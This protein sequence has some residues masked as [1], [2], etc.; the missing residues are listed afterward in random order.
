MQRINKDR[1]HESEFIRTNQADTARVTLDEVLFDS[2]SELTDSQLTSAGIAY[3]EGSGKWLKAN[4]QFISLTSI[5]ISIP[6]Y[7]AFPALSS[8]D[9]KEMPECFIEAGRNLRTEEFSGT[10]TGSDGISRVLV[11]RVKLLYD[12][13]ALLKYAVFTLSNCSEN[14]NENELLES[15]E[16]LYK[17]FEQTAVGIFSSDL[18]GRILRVN[19]KI[20]LMLQYTQEELLRMNIAEFI[21]NDELLINPIGFD[22]LAKGK[23]TIKERRIK[24]KDGSIIFAEV[25]SKMFVP[26]SFTGVVRD[27]T[28]R[29]LVEQELKESEEQ[30]RRLVELSPN[31]LLIQSGGEIVYV[32]NAGVRLFRAE[33]KMQ[34]IG[35]K[36]PALIHPDYIQLVRER[37]KV[38]SEG[39]SVPMAEEKYICMDGSIL[40]V[41]VTAA[42]FMFKGNQAVQVIMVD[43]S[44]RKAAEEEVNNYKNHLEH[45][46]LSRTA[47]LEE[48]NSKLLEEI[49]NNER[50]KEEIQNHLHFLRTLLETVPSPIYIKT[51]EKRYLD[52]NQALMDLYGFT[53][54]KA[55]GS[56]VFDVTPPEY[57]QRIDASDNRVLSELGEDKEEVEITDKQG[58]KRTVQIHKKVLLGQDGTARG[59]VGMISDITEKSDLNK[60]MEEAFLKEKELNELKSKFVSLA[61]HEFKTP[62]TSIKLYSDLLY[63]YDQSLEKTRSRAYL[64]KIQKTVDYMNE[65]VDDVLTISRVETGR[66][67]FNPQ[68]FDLKQYCFELIQEIEATYGDTKISLVFRPEYTDFVLDRKITRLILIN[69]L[70]NSVK[71]SPRPAKVRMMVDYTDNE[72][73]FVIR[74]SGIGIT[75]KDQKNL[76]EYFHRGENT[77]N[78]PGTGLG[79]AI[80]RKSVD[81]HGGAI[82]FKSR[83]NKGTTFC[84][85]IPVGR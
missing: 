21:P 54:E 24:R 18:K 13:D 65:M 5:D 10:F 36:F 33:N 2:F 28:D 26:G 29:K 55:I 35:R 27:V 62:L 74:D 66:L 8:I 69:L 7:T 19:H 11:I 31:A 68:S 51:A 9:I 49:R 23:V 52:F 3:A 46:V 56:T 1:K 30:Y 34:I 47:R 71:Y 44:K 75:E 61:S 58:R 37:M 40:D 53:R 41:E 57:A 78:I 60:K 6:F 22:T 43:I 14:R 84:V 59:I 83:V 12:N 81:M 45:L 4:G 42:P 85:K 39:N 64:E 67:D 25:S 77:G 17:I 16:K 15:S 80:V 70:S 73:A 48:L 32:N 20:C 76:F 50:A 63:N 79:L 38:L 72:I 82:S